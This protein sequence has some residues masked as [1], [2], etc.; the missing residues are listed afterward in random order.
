MKLHNAV[1]L[2]NNQKTKM[3]S[4]TSENFDKLIFTMIYCQVF[5]KLNIDFYFDHRPIQNQAHQKM[6]FKNISP[7]PYFLGIIT[8]LFLSVVFIKKLLHCTCDALRDLVA[9]AQFKKRKKHRWKSATL[10]ITLLNG[11][12]SRF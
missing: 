4:F 12:F 8:V 5:F 2:S 11:C 6:V 9:L 1:I 3:N 10:K 7:C